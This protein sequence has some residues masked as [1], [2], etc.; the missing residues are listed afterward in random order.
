MF[1]LLNVIFQT[2]Q[3]L[4]IHIK[5]KSLIVIFFCRNSKTRN[6]RV[7]LELYFIYMHIKFTKT[8]VNKYLWLYNTNLNRKE[9][10]LIPCLFIF[11]SPQNSLQAFNAFCI[12]KKRNKI[13]INKKEYFIQKLLTF[14]VADPHSC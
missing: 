14:C 2:Y 5:K 7:S 8:F 6:T 12:I 9:S 3:K 4:I 11:I 1:L 10:N 13:I